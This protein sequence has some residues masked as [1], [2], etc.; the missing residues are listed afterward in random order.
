[1]SLCFKNL[2]AYYGS[3]TKIGQGLCKKI[4]HPGFLVFRTA[5][6]KIL[7][8][9]RMLLPALTWYLENQK[10]QSA[11]IERCGSIGKPRLDDIFRAFVSEVADSDMERME[12][13]FVS[14]QKGRIQIFRPAHQDHAR[15]R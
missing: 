8:L 15:R 11:F 5:G 9:S 13:A 2:H 14:G 4:N 10:R 3:N 12:N 6:L 7:Y 1:M